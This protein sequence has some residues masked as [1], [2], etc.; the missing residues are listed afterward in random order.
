M[1]GQ[2]GD[3][4]NISDEVRT[5]LFVVDATCGPYNKLELLGRECDELGNDD[6]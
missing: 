4:D 5:L 2:L 3:N 1:V 6:L